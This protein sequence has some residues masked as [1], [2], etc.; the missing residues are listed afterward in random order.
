MSKKDPIEMDRKLLIK[1]L[2]NHSINLAS[3]IVHNPRSTESVLNR[4]CDDFYEST[5]LK[6]IEHEHKVLDQE[7]KS[8]KALAEDAEVLLKSLGLGVG[9]SK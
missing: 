7:R 6:I 3:F 8:S 4:L 2:T 5:Y 1:D 9:K